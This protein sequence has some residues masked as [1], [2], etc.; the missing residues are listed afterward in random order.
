LHLPSPRECYAHYGTDPVA[1]SFNH[2][3]SNNS[4]NNETANGGPH[5]NNAITNDARQ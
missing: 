2:A 1:Y 5:A 4:L 3:I